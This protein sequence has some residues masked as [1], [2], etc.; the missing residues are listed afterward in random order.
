LFLSI[1]ITCKKI[2]TL[3]F[4]SNFSSPSLLVSIGSTLERV[5]GSGTWHLALTQPLPKSTNGSNA[6]NL[7]SSRSRSLYLCYRQY[8]LNP[9]LLPAGFLC[10]DGMHSAIRLKSSLCSL[11]AYSYEYNTTRRVCI[12]T[13]V[14]RINCYSSTRTCTIYFFRGVLSLSLVISRTGCL[15]IIKTLLHYHAR[16]DNKNNNNN[17]KHSRFCFDQNHYS[18]FK[19]QNKKQEKK[20]SN[21]TPQC[22]IRTQLMLFLLTSRMFCTIRWNN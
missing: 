8:S 13:H 19:K 9:R 18:Q 20:I 4:Y 11:I 14:K 15:L 1:L 2:H 17:N 7:L 10:D 16:N 3:F 6:K 5:G 22:H 12:T 21:T